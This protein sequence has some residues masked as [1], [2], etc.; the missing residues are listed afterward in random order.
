MTHVVAPAEVALAGTGYGRGT[1]TLFGSLQPWPVV[2]DAAIPDGPVSIGAGAHGVAFTVDSG[3][4]V[5]ALGAQRADVT[6]PSSSAQV[7]LH[8]M[9]VLRM[10][11]QPSRHEPAGRDDLRIG[12]IRLF[13]HI[14]HQR[15]SHA[16]ALEVGLDD[17]RVQRP[18][19]C[20]LALGNPEAQPSRALA[21]HRRPCHPRL[22]IGGDGDAHMCMV[23]GPTVRRALPGCPD[24]RAVNVTINA[25]GIPVHAGTWRPYALI[26]TF[27]APE[28]ASGA[29]ALG[30]DGQGEQIVIS[31]LGKANT[32]GA[33]F[34]RHERRTGDEG[35]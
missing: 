1:I 4:L 29:P 28:R 5:R 23:P 18:H 33:C 10:P 8:Q 6:L 26:D 32:T 15:A 27:T 24:L 20:T 25:H 17:G 31:M 11:V 2:S 34:G 12:L 3:E 22:G 14:A 9:V 13:D 16:L 19:G 30:S 35:T 21:A 7:V